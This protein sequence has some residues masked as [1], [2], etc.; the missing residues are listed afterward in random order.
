LETSLHN[1]PATII[2]ANKQSLNSPNL[3]NL[4][5]NMFSNNNVSGASNQASSLNSPNPFSNLFASNGSD[6]SSLFG[7]FQNFGLGGIGQN[8]QRN[9]GINHIQNLPNQLENPNEY[10]NLMVN[11]I[12][13]G[14]SNDKDKIKKTF[15][16]IL[17]HYENDPD[18]NETAKE[19]IV[20]MREI[21]QDMN[22]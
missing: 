9:L 6:I 22:K 10:L 8:N 12:L 19:E 5:Q 15:N 1:E 16:D 2:N 3:F 7:V 14:A 21:A 18:I 20:K 11:F 13:A 17:D 4:L